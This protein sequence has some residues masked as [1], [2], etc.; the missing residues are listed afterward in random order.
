MKKVFSI[1][2]VLLLAFALVGCN[3]PENGDGNGNGNGNGGDTPAELVIT[4]SGLDAAEITAG[5]EF[6]VLTGVK[7]TGNDKKDYTDKITVAAVNGTITNNILKSDQVGNVTLAYTVQLTDPEYFTRALRTVTIKAAEKPEGE[8]IANPNFEDGMMFWETYGGAGAAEFT[9]DGE[10]GMKIELTAIGDAWEPRITQMNVPFEKDKAYKIS[11]EAKALEPKTI[12]LQV[13]E[14]LPNDPWFTDFKPGQEVHR[15]IGTEWATYEFEFQMNLEN[16]RGGVLFEMGKVGDD[17]TITTLWLRNVKAEETTLGADEVPPVITTQDLTLLVN[18]EFDPLMLI[19]SIRDERDGEIDKSEATYVIKKGED[20]VTEV[21]NTVEGEYT[22]EFAVK[23]K[24]GN[25]ATATATVK[26]TNMVFKDDNKIKNGEFTE[27]NDNWVTWVAD[28]NSTDATFENV[29]GAMKIDVTNTGEVDWNVQVY[30]EEFEAIVGKTYKVSFDLKAS[31]ERTIGFEVV[32]GANAENP[33]PILAKQTVNVTTETQ[34]FSYLYTVTRAPETSKIIFMF[35]GGDPAHYILDNVEIVEADLPEYL[36]NPGLKELYSWRVFTNDW[37]GSVA[38][39]KVEEEEY[40]INISK[41][42]GPQESWRLQFIQDKFAVTQDIAF[43]N[44]GI[45]SLEADKEYTFSFYAYASKA[46]TL[47]AVI[48]TGPNEWTNLIAET[49]KEVAITTEKT[50]YTITFTTPAD[51]SGDLIVKFEFGTEFEPFGEEDP[52]QKVVFADLSLKEAEGENLLI[53]GEAKHYTKGYIFEHAS[54]DNYGSMKFTEE[55]LEVT[56]TG[57]GTEP[58][59]PHVFQGD[60]NLDAG[61][62]NFKV[63]IESSVAR[64]IRF[65]LVVPAEGYRSLLPDSKVDLV[66]TNEQIGEYLVAEV[67]F[68]LATPVNGVKLEIDFGKVAEDDSDVPGVFVIK[69]IQLYRKFD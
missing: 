7:A 38:D 53:E 65:N 8:M 55:G 42:A 16:D 39:L 54:A 69:E 41:F 10:N 64:T 9:P 1:L 35:A 61:K 57:V 22:I 29:D 12:N 50:L 15:L 14:I 26:F 20:V 67:S 51:H 11:F 24:A 60:I 34:T 3:K 36:V 44:K 5:D 43:D 32:D 47:T 49:D 48:S 17:D 21:D 37:E 33:V 23:D 18:S 40:V 4:F 28:W 25:E 59:I 2:A 19:T 52:A 13:G 63:L 46:I 66:V 62:Y 56:T 30:Q 58:H 68:E 45:I 31:I 27:N 6:N